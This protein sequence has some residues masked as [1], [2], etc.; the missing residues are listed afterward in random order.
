MKQLIVRRVYLWVIMLNEL[1]K[2]TLFHGRAEKLFKKT[3]IVSY[4]FVYLKSW[5]KKQGI[6]TMAPSLSS[7]P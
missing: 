6:D 2:G 1:Y 3:E 4:T 7:M 5:T